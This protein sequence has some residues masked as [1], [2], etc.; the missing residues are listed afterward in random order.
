MTGTVTMTRSISYAAGRAAWS[1]TEEVNF[2]GNTFIRPFIRKITGSL[3]VMGLEATAVLAVT[4]ALRIIVKLPDLTGIMILIGFGCRAGREGLTGEI[5][6]ASMI[7]WATV[8]VVH[9]VIG[10][11]E[12]MG[13]A[14]HLGATRAGCGL[15]PFAHCQDLAGRVLKNFKADMM[16]Y[17][18]R[19]TAPWRMGAWIRVRMSM[20]DSASGML[21]L[22]STMPAAANGGACVASRRS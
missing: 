6:T 15:P 18:T 10:T 16:Q 5:L 17:P 11:G 9:T 19:C 8:N 2:L 21:M 22:L 13:S 7:L 14:D 1:Q 20:K 12:V 4:R 3:N